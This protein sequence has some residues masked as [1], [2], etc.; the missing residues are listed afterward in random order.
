MLKA[1]L[2]D[3]DGTLLDTIPDIAA[4]LNGGL[5]ACGL[6][7]HPPRD[8]EAFIGGGIREAVT[9]AAPAGTPEE[10]LQK[11]LDRYHDIYVDHCTDATRPYPG[12][13]D[14]LHALSH[15]GLIL[16]V[17][18]NKTEA[19]AQKIIAHFFPNVPFRCVFGRAEG[20]PLKPHTG[21]AAPALA[22]LG[23]PPAEI[24]YVGDSGTD[25]TFA[26]AA[27]MLA[28]AAP[29]GYR[30]REELAACGA[31][32]LPDSPTQLGKAL[33]ANFIPH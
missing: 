13:E 29:W 26:K 17:L 7:I 2:F 27:G 20:R 30:S 28:V 3:L 11:V 25:M 6:P 4:G 33:L 5:A 31:D 19:T 9:K 12:V 15:Q 8:C 1:V 18:S 22:A 23:L 24:A 32:L 16:G 10:V 21:A 14:M